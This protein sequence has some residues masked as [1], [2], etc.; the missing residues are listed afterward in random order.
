[1]HL[2]LTPQ[3]LPNVTSYNVIADLKGSDHPEQIVVV[4]GHLDS[5]DLGQGAIDDG[6]GVVMAME[7]AEVL[8]RLHLRPR[9]TL[10]VIAWMDEENGGG[11][12]DAYGKEHAAEMANHIAAI[13]SDTGAAHPIGFVLKMPPE[14]LAALHP[15]SEVLGPT[16][17][18]MF[19]PI[20]SSPGSDI[21]PLVKAG[22]PGIGIIQDSRRYFDYHHSAA[23]TLDKV[24]PQELKENA[25]AMA[26]MGYA[27]AAM[28]EPLPGSQK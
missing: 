18:T 20:D 21:D 19:L 28:P 17:A 27:L 11:G 3:T 7:A 25:A 5:W 16:G 8:Q 15:V 13:E 26:V 1:M 2:L 24:D 4:S 6:A 22:V 12:H 9:R 14:A 10:R 23:D